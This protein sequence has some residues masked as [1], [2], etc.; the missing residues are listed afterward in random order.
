VKSAENH[1]TPGVLGAE[2]VVLLVDAETETVVWASDGFGQVT[3]HAPSSAEG[4]EAARLTCL[5]LDVETIAAARA[6]LE[7]GRRFEARLRGFRWD[8]RPLQLEL[9]VVRLPEHVRARSWLVTA[10]AVAE[11]RADPAAAPALPPGGVERI[12][13]L[14]EEHGYSGELLPG[15]E[16]RPHYI[17]PGLETLLGAPLRGT[18]DPGARWQ[19]AIPSEDLAAYHA[20][21]DDLRRGR[22]AEIEYRIR[23]PDGGV[24]HVVERVRPTITPGG[25]VLL[26]GVVLDV[27][28]QRSASA[29]LSHVVEAID[30]YLYTVEIRGGRERSL[31]R[32]PGRRRLLGGDG[33]AGADPDEEWRAAVHPADRDAY[34]AAVERNSRGE[35]SQVEYRLVGHDG[36]ERW[37]WERNHPRRDGTRLVFDGIVTDITERRLQ[38]ELLHAAVAEVNGVNEALQAQRAEAERLSRTD[39]LTGVANRRQFAETLDAE[40]EQVAAGTRGSAVLLLDI[41]HFKHVNDAY[42]HHAGDRVLTAVASRI[43]AGV[44]EDDCVARWGGEEFAVLL[45]ALPDAQAIRRIGEAIRSSVA[46]DPVM[47]DDDAIAVTVSIGGVRLG[48]EHG[49]LEA[50]MNAADQALYSAK[51]HGR[52][53]VRLHDEL[54]MHDVVAEVPEAVHLARTL[55]LVTAT[56]E[57]LPVLQA[58]RIAD[59]AAR[60]AER[61][62]ASSALALRARLTGWLHDI[63]KVVVPDQILMKPGPLAEREWAVVRSHTEFGEQIVRRIG[64]LSEA[65]TGVRHHHERF[66]GTGY[67]DRLAGTAIPLEARIVAVVDAFTAMTTGRV[68]QPARSPAEAMAELER[69]SGTQLDP[70]VVAAL[71]EALDDEDARRRRLSARRA[72]DAGA[73]QG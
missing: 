46:Y 49:T 1:T 65:A 25:R 8:Q 62:E 33:P 32:G 11:Q 10:R 52:N 48:A 44:R 43:R 5:G 61:L 23:R 35:P 27:T 34:D 31:W 12:L 9:R 68:H 69:V 73:A 17:G 2:D 24:R 30:E 15:G 64:G 66:D 22:A 51:R 21:D 39:W 14:F 47:I 41:D 54:S 16:Y 72:T 29:S 59:L 56:R 19:A 45:T 4:L 3:G 36:R 18:D 53:Q 50:T 60:L 67:P 42:G 58:A 40:L 13:G 55:A 71:R 37:V 63:G 6:A 28:G 20:R 38:S 7:E 57:G 70:A 26:D